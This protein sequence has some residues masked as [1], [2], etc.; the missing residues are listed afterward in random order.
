ML[1]T[2][3]ASGPLAGVAS[4]LS[5]AASAASATPTGGASV[6]AVGAPAVIGAFI[7]AM[8]L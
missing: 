4:S 6:K 7:A 5:S 2:A 8:F 1:T 3:S